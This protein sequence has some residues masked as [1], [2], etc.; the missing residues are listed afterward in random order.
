MLCGLSFLCLVFPTL[1][2]KTHSIVGL[3]DGLTS[4]KMYRERGREREGERERE[5]K[6]GEKR[7]FKLRTGASFVIFPRS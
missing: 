4:V 2:I 6:R 5:R 1:M 7:T 3:C